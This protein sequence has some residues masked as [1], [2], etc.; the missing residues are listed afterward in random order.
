MLFVWNSS[1]LAVF[2]LWLLFLFPVLR[3]DNEYCKQS[4]AGSCTRGRYRGLI[5]DAGSSGSRIHIFAWDPLP[6]NSSQPPALVVPTFLGSQSVNPG[7]TSI[8]SLS[9]SLE[10]LQQ[11]AMEVLEEERDSWHRYPVYLLATAG[12]RRQGPEH[13]DKIMLALRE[14]LARWPFY[15][16]PEFVA[17]LS[18]EEEGAYGWLAL[19]AERGTL[20][21]AAE[22]SYGVLDLGGASFQ[23]TFMPGT[24]HQVLQSS[25]P[26][27][28]RGQQAN[29]YAASYLQF[30]IQEAQRLLQRHLIAHT[31]MGEAAAELTHPCLPHGLQYADALIG[32]DSSPEA[33]LRAVW[34]G[35]GSYDE[36]ASKIRELF[37]KR[38]ACYTP[39]CTFGG[40]YQPRLGNQRFVAFSTFG[41]VIDELALTPHKTTLEDIENAARY[42]CKMDWDTVQQRWRDLSELSLRMLCF[43]ATYV[44]QLLHFGLGFDKKNLQIEFGTIGN[45]SAIS[46]ASGAMI[47]AANNWF[48]EHQPK[49]TTEE[50]I[51]PSQLE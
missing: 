44:V 51:C 24:G 50:T 12:L 43:K 7:V 21:D 48:N 28:L 32:D 26:M 23:I 27:L 16:K 9:E 38:A 41:R 45:A 29:L 11:Y 34:Q 18:G 47:W 19:N 2:A 30:G 14:S 13:R 8:D 1:S 15:F 20:D 46:W 37:D 17:I 25:H 22:S 42:V 4:D 49:C 3:A 10:V 36:C 5:I 31:L 33:S 39:P 40:R 35:H 6:C